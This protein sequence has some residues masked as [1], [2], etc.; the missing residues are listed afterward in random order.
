MS[1]VRCGGLSDRGR[2][3]EL[4]EDA[5]ALRP[6]LGLFL[7][8]DGMGGAARGD[9]A[10]RIV[11]ETLPSLVGRFL[12]NQAWDLTLVQ[13]PVREAM[14]QLSL[15]VRDAAGRHPEFLG[16]GST[17]VLALVRETSALIAHMG[18]SRAYALKSGVLARLTRDHSVVQMLIDSGEITPKDAAS[19]PARNQ[20]TQCVGMEEDPLPGLVVV[21]L[22]AGDRLLL[23]TDGLTNMV[24]DRVIGDVLAKGMG[25][26]QTCEALVAEANGAGGVDNI[27]VVVVDF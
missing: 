12:G 24:G 19:H 14:R 4:N 23:C 27:T 3:R 13:E 22:A 25:P 16:M 5:L 11:A 1:Q 2:V 7:V 17:V 6:D 10:S 9:L 18:D 20:I 26:E 21:S 15:H 8:A